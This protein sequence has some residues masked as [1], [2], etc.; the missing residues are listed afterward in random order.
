MS[1]QF[2][3]TV[4][5]D[6]YAEEG[7]L[8]EHGLSFALRADGK[9]IL[10]DTGNGETLIHNA[11][12]LG[13]DLANITQ[14]VLSHGHYDHTGGIAEL[15]HHNQHCQIIAHPFVLTE[16]YSLHPDK[17]S[18]RISMP[19]KVLSALQQTSASRLQ[20]HVTPFRLSEKIGITGTIPRISEFEDTGGPFFIDKTG[21]FADSLPDDQAMWVNTSR[22][23]IIVLGC[24]HSGLANTLHYVCH[25]SGESRV[26][27]IIGG[28]HLLHASSTR[29]E[30]TVSILAQLNPDF[31]YAG[32]CTGDDTITTIQN[33]LP[34]LKIHQLYA[35]LHIRL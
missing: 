16:R 13:I 23:L 9:N 17:P 25:I 12:K 20:F 22:G 19:S 11:T 24:C 14:L 5:C 3:L 21:Q 31:I 4:I 18:R 1:C 27:G 6:N 30:Q 7:L 34:K 33:K 29:I 2:E 32:H 10:F 35:G 26:A 15:L 8:S 28:L